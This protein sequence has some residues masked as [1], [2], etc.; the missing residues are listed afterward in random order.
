[1]PEILS[2]EELDELLGEDIEETKAS[3]QDALISDAGDVVPYDFKRPNRVS[4][5]QIRSFRGIHDKMGRS[6]S[7]QIS[8]TIRSIAEFSLTSVEQM[9]YGEFLASLPNPTSFNIFSLK[10]IDGTG[11]LEINPNLAFSIIDRLLGGSGDEYSG[12]REFSDIELNLLD[13]VLK[14]IMGILKEVWAPIVEIYPSIDA[15]ESSPNVIQIVAQNEIVLT[16]K[17]QATIGKTI[18]NIS[19]CYPVISLEGFL[20]RLGSRDLLLSETSNKKSRNKEL[21][22]ILGGAK[23]KVSAHIG[24]AKLTLG[25][26]MN[27]SAGDIIKLDKKADDMAI[28]AIDDKDKFEA[29]MGVQDYHKMVKITKHIISE[30]QELKDILRGL[31]QERKAQIQELN[32]EDDDE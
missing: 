14:Q 23:V 2:Q 24:R 25:E 8:A 15:K 16:A 10:P 30:K 31:E 18:G 3:V 20:N 1:M 21:H 11:V 22:A 12:E 6:L 13:S 28:I 5:D 27:L 4:K 29:S 19:F 26:M 7:A 32:R 9:T 17:V